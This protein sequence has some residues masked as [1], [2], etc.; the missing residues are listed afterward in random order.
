MQLSTL[1]VFDPTLDL[2]LS[3]FE[4]CAFDS[5]EEDKSCVFIF[6]AEFVFFDKK[7]GDDWFVDELESCF[8]SVKS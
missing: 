5:D 6:A 7:G 3:E 2:E 4:T 1:S 8:G